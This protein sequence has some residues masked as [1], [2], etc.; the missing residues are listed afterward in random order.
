MKKIIYACLLLTSNIVISCEYSKEE[1]IC[2]VSLTSHIV[3]IDSADSYKFPRILNNGIL[4]SGKDEHYC[5]ILKGYE[6]SKSDTLFKFG[7]GHNEF[8]HMAFGKGVDG[9]LLLLNSP[10]V[11]NKLIS[12]TNIGKDSIE[13]MKN[14][15]CWK[16]HN[17][18]SLP[19]FRYATRTFVSLSDSTILIPGAPFSAI[20]H[21]LSIIDYKNQKVFPLEYWPEDGI[22]CE[23]LV[24]HAVYT[25]NCSLFSNSKGRF[26][27][28][29]NSERFAFVFSIEGNKI[30]AIK[31]LYSV[32]P[33]YQTDRSKR[34]YEYKAISTEALECTANSNCIYALLRDSDRKGRKLDKWKNPYIYG[35]IVQVFDWN[36]NLVKT[37]RLDKFGQSVFVSDDNKILYLF[38]NDYFEEDSKPEIW[39]YNL[40]EL[41]I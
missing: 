21:I 33:D 15:N 32:H 1:I 23:N 12:L 27:Y 18:L 17:L 38:T 34:N 35:N 7:N 22:E 28:Q 19:A 8:Q 26:L 4:V 36:G 16:K 24:K 39:A 2:D 11:G 6:C 30:S 37:I 20:G 40:S 9:S 29:C 31:E 10:M 14:V 5:S 3:K 13:A 41:N 25:D